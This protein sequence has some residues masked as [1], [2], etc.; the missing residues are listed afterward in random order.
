MSFFTEEVDH[1]QRGKAEDDDDDDNA[2]E[3]DDEEDKQKQGVLCTEKK[4]KAQRHKQNVQKKTS[5][6]KVPPCRS[7]ES[8]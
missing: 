5:S 8:D 6:C 7:C 4:Q 3:D 2:D 1:N